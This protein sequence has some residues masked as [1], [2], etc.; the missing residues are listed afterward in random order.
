MWSGYLDQP[1]EIPPEVDKGALDGGIEGNS[2]NSGFSSKFAGVLSL[3]G[4]VHD[5]NWIN[6]GDVPMAMVQCA[7]D[8]TVHPEGGIG[9]GSKFQYYGGTAV[10]ARAAH[11]S[12]PKTLLT[13]AGS[14]HC[15]RPI[16]PTGLDSTVDFF[17]KSAYG[18]MTAPPTTRIEVVLTRQ[19]FQGLA[20]SGDAYDVNG[21]MV[22]SSG[23]D[24]PASSRVRAFRAGI[25]FRKSR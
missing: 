5:T 7:G 1:G 9:T 2:G 21:V 22:R 14:C 10:A 13:Y 23:E 17:A 20:G 11:V 4:A 6:T 18:F 3:S 16:G 15:P 25:Y 19:A 8:P 24:K 12:V